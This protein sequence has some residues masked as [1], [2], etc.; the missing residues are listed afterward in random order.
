M[1]YG[2]GEESLDSVKTVNP[3]S[4]VE[5][6]HFE[7]RTKIAIYTD[8]NQLTTFNGPVFPVESM[9]AKVL[10]GKRE[11]DSVSLP[12]FWA[13]S[14]QR[15]YLINKIEPL[16]DEKLTA[17]SIIKDHEPIPKPD[18][19]G[20]NRRIKESNFRI[21]SIG[22][23]RNF[24]E[25]YST[26]LTTVKRKQEV[27]SLAQKN[28]EAFWPNRHISSHLFHSP[29]NPFVGIVRTDYDAVHQPVL[30]VF[31]SNCNVR[32]EGLNFKEASDFLDFHT[33]LKCRI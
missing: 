4:I 25:L 31:C 28:E 30:D 3:N 13:T 1:K 10:L 29:R 26:Y 7:V 16:V 24:S 27:A 8:G 32:I 20:E 5:L 12:T 2:S 22:R 19:R 17:R 14:G 15:N 33:G 6:F 11:G 18:G 23:Y 21:V 9:E